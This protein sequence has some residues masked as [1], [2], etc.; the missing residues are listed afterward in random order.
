M[1]G[2]WEL[3][4][5]GEICVIKGR[6]GYRGYTKK[7]LVSEGEGAIS[8]SP[9]NIKNNQIEYDNST[10]ISWFKYEESPEIMVFNG[11]IIYCKTASIGKIALIEKLPVKAT[12]NPQF[13]VLKDLACLNKYLFYYLNSQRFK[14]QERLIISGTAVPTLSQTNLSQ[15]S[16]PIPPLPEQQRIVAILYKAFAAIDKAKANTEQNLKNAKELWESYL[17]GV[18]W[19]KEKD[20]EEKRFEDIIER[21]QIGLIKSSKEQSAHNEFRYLKMD[22]ITIDNQLI[23]DKYVY[24]NATNDEQE[25]FTLKDGDLLFNT[26]NSFELV[27]KSCVFTSIDD[28][29]VLF[30]NNIMRILF[31]QNISSKY[32][33]YCLTSGQL[34]DR[35]ESLKSG[36]TGVSGI[37]WSGLREL[38]IPIP[39]FDEQIS[40]SNQLDK[41]YS[42]IKNLKVKFQM[43][44]HQLEEL[45]KSLLQK[46]FSGE[47][48][49]K[50][51]EV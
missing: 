2:G 49:A 47:L 22:S 12:I 46:A 30:N 34:R 9:S 15:I 11:D 27:G 17:E 19:D 1:R 8:L 14:E 3:K 23:R 29:P 39:S 37:Y 21:T 5:L 36:T 50:M 25:R 32:I 41:F 6:I 10:Y 43:K 20:W 16:V 45:K 40:L 42:E 24:V 35:L 7:D 38:R 13:V 4:K 31:R 26:R 51:V 48:T 44:L 28:D 18:F 33:N